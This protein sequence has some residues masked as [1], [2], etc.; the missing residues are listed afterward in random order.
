MGACGSKVTEEERIMRERN[1]EIERE[2]TKEKRNQDK[3]IKILLLG[4]GESGK[5]TI[6]KQMRIIHLSGFSQQEKDVFKRQI[7]NNIITQ[8]QVLLKQCEKRGIELL[9]ENRESA[10]E[11]LDISL[12]GRVN[13]DTDT[14]QKVAACYKDPAIAQ[15]MGFRKEFTLSDSAEYFLNDCEKYSAEDYVPKDEDV[16]RVRAKT[17]GIVETAFVIRKKRFRMVDVGGQRN[18][19]KKWMHCFQDVT[20]VIYCASLND[21]DLV[22]EEDPTVN[23]MHE[24]LNL[25]GDIINNEWFSNTSII[26]FL[27]KRDLFEKKLE[28]GID[29]KSCFP[30]YDDGCKKEKAMEYIKKKYLEKNKFS[31]REIYSHYT[32]AT[33]TQN[34]KIVFN[35]VQD[36]L[37]SAT[38]VELGV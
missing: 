16:L 28:S 1:R 5:S 32:I 21:Y 33:D 34:I 35:A 17:T 25:F 14:A 6:A 9:P 36:I 29:L 12:L 24:S 27:N 19:R 23:R 30:L 7:H 4:A 8:I 38:I 15:V 10:A 37:L 11:I 13:Y 3:E 2:L 18:E 20:A 31:N 22:L 26:L